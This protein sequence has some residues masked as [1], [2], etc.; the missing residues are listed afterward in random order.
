MS[1]LDSV[2][3]PHFNGRKAMECDGSKS[4]FDGKSSGQ[5]IMRS[6]LAAEL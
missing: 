3:A 6:R 4:S 2:G 5:C 1:D